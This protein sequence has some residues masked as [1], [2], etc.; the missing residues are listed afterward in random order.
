[1]GV[2]CHLR[3]ERKKKSRRQERVKDWMV[4]DPI[5]EFGH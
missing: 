3:K 5:S 1:M 4:V 2:V